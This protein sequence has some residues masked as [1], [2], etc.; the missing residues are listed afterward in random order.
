MKYS[1]PLIDAILV[2]RYNRFLA[3]VLLDGYITTVLCPNTGSMAG[4]LDEGNPVR[5][6]GPHG[7]KRKYPFTLEQI[8]IKRPDYRKIWVGIN[9]TIP[10]YITEELFRNK[11]LRGF[12]KYE[13][14]KREVK[15]SDHS[16]IDLKLEGDGLPPC[17]VEVKN[18]TLVL[19]NPELRNVGLNE[20]EIAAF[21]DAKTTRG[22]KHLREL[23][24]KVDSGD[25][26]AMVY[27]I[28][29][30]DSKRFAPAGGYD[31]EYAETLSLALKKGVEIIPLKA[32]VTRN[33]V[34]LLNRKLEIVS[35]IS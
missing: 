23:M 26:A 27:T 10:N 15:I 24:D 34:H 35:N 14:V 16:R 29:R 4:L 18:V 6:S 31:A 12:E 17:W 19:D 28:Q 1:T 7:G 13:I 11:R 20:G 3:D 25:R 32:R 2:K 22:V 33:G 8:R 5:I 9:T 30:A 21:P